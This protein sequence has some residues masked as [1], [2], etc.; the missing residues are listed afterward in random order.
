MK[1]LT[2]F[3]LLLGGM[4][5]P[6]LTHAMETNKRKREEEKQENVLAVK[7][8]KTEDAQAIR[9]LP[10]IQ[11]D[12]VQYP[13]VVRMLTEIAASQVTENFLTGKEAIHES[14]A[15]I[16]EEL[17]TYLA[18]RRLYYGRTL[19]HFATDD[20]NV[21]ALRLA[22]A[23]CTAV[24]AD[25]N[26]HLSINE[27]SFGRTDFHNYI[28][29]R[30]LN[31]ANEML[32]REGNELNVS[33]Q[34]DLG[35]TPL[36][37]AIKQ[38]YFALVSKIIRILKEQGKLE[39]VNV[40]NKEDKTVLYFAVNYAPHLVPLLLEHGAIEYG[41]LFNNIITHS[42]IIPI[43]PNILGLIDDDPLRPFFI[44]AIT[45]GGATEDFIKNYS[46]AGQDV[47]VCNKY[48]ETTLMLLTIRSGDASKIAQLLI[49]LGTKVN[50]KDKQGKSALEHVIDAYYAEDPYEEIGMK[51][52]HD[53]FELIQTLVNNRAEIS[54]ELIEKIKAKLD[55]LTGGPKKSWQELIDYL[56]KNR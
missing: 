42:H 30:D 16:P 22:G 46:A 41:K 40:Q 26:I 8:P 18:Q 23:D 1:K 32:A 13:R 56:E 25:G 9:A 11:L 17:R 7:K 4:V 54:D 24:D 3:L 34:D 15:R 47:N 28:C 33:D 19:L 53:L 36:I 12:E 29:T 51:D 50:T 14:F 27:S 35:N 39:A 45:E 55:N 52:K 21:E 43:A 48:G 38:G 6:A 44:E 5:M 31:K 37:D 2:I 49:S 20:K 10:E